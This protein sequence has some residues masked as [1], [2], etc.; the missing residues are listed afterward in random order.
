MLLTGL[1][2]SGPV[3]AYEDAWTLRAGIGGG[4]GSR[5]LQLQRVSTPLDLS[6][7]YG[8]NDA[9]GLTLSAHGA[10][11]N[12]LGVPGEPRTFVGGGWLGVE[13]VVDLFRWVPYVPLSVGWVHGS[14]SEHGTLSAV[15]F[16]AGLGL[17]YLIHPTLVVGGLVD[18]AT[19]APSSGGVPDGEG[20]DPST[21]QYTRV[22]FYV[23]KIIRR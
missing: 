14:A 1:G 16:R 9:W 21:G 4:L 7:S 11:V 18:M 2:W 12:D 5:S 6:V 19:L 15:G 3:Q 8:L 22:L 17:D 13:Y 10:W 23:G 20:R